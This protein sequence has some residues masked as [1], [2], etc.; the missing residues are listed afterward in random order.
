[1]HVP[2]AHHV[3]PEAASISARC[4]NMQHQR[5]ES[6]HTR[7]L[8][9][10]SGSWKMQIPGAGSVYTSRMSVMIRLQQHHHHQPP[11]YQLLP[12][13]W[14][15]DRQL[16]TNRMH[17]VVGFWLKV[18]SATNGSHGLVRYAGL[19]LPL[20][21][22]VGVLL[23]LLLDTGALPA[24]S[25]MSLHDKEQ[26]LHQHH[27]NDNNDQEEGWDGMGWRAA[28]R[29]RT[30]HSMWVVGWVGPA[31]LGRWRCLGVV[32]RCLGE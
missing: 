15:I 4:R 16:D 24:E 27:D 32:G 2:V 10:S 23:P 31:C 13:S 22:V 20:L 3:A 11:A 12:E 28:T 29:M 1:M 21:L 7:T 18:S 8:V 9:T 25:S 30:S 26:Q 6:T 19:L 5:V 17:A 14:H